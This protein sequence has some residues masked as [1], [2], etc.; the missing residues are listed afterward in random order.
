MQT[1]VDLAGFMILNLNRVGFL[2]YK[3]VLTHHTRQVS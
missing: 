3:P 2:V 1:L